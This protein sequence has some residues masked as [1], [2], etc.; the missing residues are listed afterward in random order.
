MLLRNYVKLPSPT[1]GGR[2]S[3]SADTILYESL[4]E[5]EAP[6]PSGLYPLNGTE[7]PNL[8]GLYPLNGT[9]APN[10]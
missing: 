3:L 6:Y 7:A 10:L 9:E 8:S 4:N 1:G 5:A 2:Y